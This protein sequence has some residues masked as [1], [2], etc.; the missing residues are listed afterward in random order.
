MY[1]PKVDA[2]VYNIQHGKEEYYKLNRWNW[3][4]FVI[5]YLSNI[6]KLMEAVYYSARKTARITDIYPHDV[7]GPHRG[8]HKQ[9]NRHTPY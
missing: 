8:P 3:L 5:N 6:N 2:G 4:V 1:V 7:L 9:Y